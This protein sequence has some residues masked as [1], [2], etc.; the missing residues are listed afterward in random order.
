[1]FLGTDFDY[2][3]R[4]MT[5]RAHSRP[6]L[7]LVD[8]APE[9]LIALG[10]LL[11]DEYSLKVTRSGA[12]ALAAISAGAKPD[13]ILLDVTMPQMD[14]YETLK[15]LRQGPRAREIPVIFLTAC[16]SESEE[17]LGFAL[18][19]ADYITKP[20]RPSVVRARVRAQLEAKQAR[21][22][23][24][25]SNR[26]LT[27]QLQRRIEENEAVQHAS[28]VALAQLAEARDPETGNHI[29]RTQGYVQILADELAVTAG[30]GTA[31][32]DFYRKQLVRSA[33]LHDIG[34]VGIPDSVLLK[35]GRLTR[36]EFE[37]MKTH[38]V[39]GATALE[40]AMS[41]SS[42]SVAF[43]E[44][45]RQI[46]RSH[47]ERWDGTGYPDG[48]VEDEIPLSARIMA[49]ADAF[50]AI[51]SP[52]VYKEPIPIETARNIILAGA[53]TQF[54]PIVVGAFDR[55]FSHFEALALRLADQ[56]HGAA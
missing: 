56:P 8:D 23:L 3:H 20:F 28:L 15:R 49:V 42:A 10:S 1:M 37:V 12:D 54:D 17:E 44:I 32:D 14:G 47:H 22:A 9:N 52:R 53:A 33:P 55:A 18:G 19:A 27:E 7:L 6:T 50:D 43:L 51:V 41:D 40:R 5:T 29:Q 46:A 25:Q 26:G 11:S 4:L 39:L 24:R 45:A 13:L 34:K 16:K 31:L 48:L 30:Y 21:D 35:P 38:T 2:D 36:E